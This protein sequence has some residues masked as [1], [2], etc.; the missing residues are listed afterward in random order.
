VAMVNWTRC[1][2]VDAE[3]SP[4]KRLTAYDPKSYPILT[5]FSRQDLLA[6]TP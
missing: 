2:Y 1:I 4:F 5:G 3:G 6:R